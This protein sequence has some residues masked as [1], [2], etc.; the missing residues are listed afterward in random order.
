MGLALAGGA[1]EVVEDLITDDASHLEALLAR[2][3]VDDHVAMDADE[4]LRVKDAVLILK[5]GVALALFAVQLKQQLCV[6]LGT[7]A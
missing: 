2:D 3:R 7:A 5:R 6:L 1:Y 4:V